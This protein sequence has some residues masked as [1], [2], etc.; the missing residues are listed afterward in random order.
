M[1]DL[2]IAN[3]NV[4]M[5]WLG[6]WA[7]AGG[8]YSRRVRHMLEG[9]MTESAR[10]GLLAEWL[11]QFRRPSSEAARAARRRI[12]GEVVALTVAMLASFVALDAFL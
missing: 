9:E 11:Q 7:V 8:L 1:F 10:H 2:R 6:F 4:G 5:A 3:G 12:R